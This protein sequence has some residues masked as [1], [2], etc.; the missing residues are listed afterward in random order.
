MNEDKRKN[1]KETGKGLT[2]ETVLSVGSDTAA[3]V[4]KNSIT[5][6]VGDILVDTAGSLIPGVSGAVQNYKRNRFERNMTT[7]AEY[8]YTKIEDIRVNLEHK[9]D[10]QKEKID[11]LFHYVM[12]YVIDEQQEDK[13]EYMVNGFVN[14]TEHEQV[15]DDFILTYYDVLKE[16]RIVDISVLRLMYSSRFMFDQEARET[17]QDV[18]ERRGISYEQY[19]SVRRNLLRIGLL[20]TKTDLNITDDLDE[21]AKRFKELY[22]YLDKL[23][24]PRNKGSLPKLKEPKMKSKENFEMSKFGRDFVEFFLG[25]DKE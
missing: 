5:S 15:S 22:T 10:E 14:I 23:T 8:L 16:L 3:E 17:F 6:V 1:L 12:D 2:L 21:I 11:Q 13:I 18:M 4:A 7:F 24:N 20:T 25:L 9:S 19:E